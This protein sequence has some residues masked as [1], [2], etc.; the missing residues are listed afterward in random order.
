MELRDADGAAGK[1]GN[2]LQIA[3]EGRNDPPE[4]PVLLTGSLADRQ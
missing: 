4:H 3:P 1:M 2:D